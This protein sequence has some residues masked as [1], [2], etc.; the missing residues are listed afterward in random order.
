MLRVQIGHAKEQK[1]AINCVHCREPIEFS[2]K[3]DQ[4]NPS[5]SFAVVDNCERI[6][7]TEEATPYYVSSD[8]AVDSA[9]LHDPLYFPSLQTMQ[10]LMQHP[11]GRQM[12][13]DAQ[14][15][16]SQVVSEIWDDVQKIWRLQ[17]S[18]KY[19]VANQL[20]AQ[21]CARNGISEVVLREVLYWFNG[22]LFAIDKSIDREV[23]E[24]MRSNRDEC[25]RFLNYYHFNLRPHHRR[26]LFEI[27]SRY[28]EA[29]SEFSQVLMYARI[30]V[31]LPDG[32]RVT[33]T[34]FSMVRRFYA[35]AYEFFASFVAIYACLNNIKD[36]RRFDEFKNIGLSKYL[37][38]DKAKRRDAFADNKLFL[39]A[40]AEFDNDIRNAS[41]HDWFFLLPDNETIEFRPGGTGVT[42][43]VSY[44]QYLYRCTA[45]FR[46]IVSLFSV[47]LRF[48]EVI[49]S[50]SLV[51][52]P[53]FQKTLRERT[54]R[55]A[56]LLSAAGLG[57]SSTRALHSERGAGGGGG[58]GQRQAENFIKAL[59]RLH[60]QVQ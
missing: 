36:G 9:R 53:T 51:T 13:R 11:N 40:S 21:F 49:N 4:K 22:G 26:S 10:Y 54:E 41:F 47:T 38:T 28:F 23:V 2:L 3:L 59:G 8:I 35:D 33:S 24:I 6:E 34:K 44:S 31:P 14:R 58:G 17:N 27:Y 48:D 20:M 57:S 19:A 32:F 16:N 45:L 1:H 15:P 5:I 12:F 29:F 55:H 39:E 50:T 37:T 25:L 18:G 30:D 43:T 52:S 60:R 42:Q 46:Q 56:R 7:P